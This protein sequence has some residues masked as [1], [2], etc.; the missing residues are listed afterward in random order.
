MQM[1]EWHVK[2][3]ERVCKV[4]AGSSNV[5]GTGGNG[6]LSGARRSDLDVFPGFKPSLE[7]CLLDWT[8]YP[9]EGITYADGGACRWYSP[10]MHTRLLEHNPR[11]DSIPDGLGGSEHLSSLCRRG[12]AVDESLF[13]F[14]AAVGHAITE[15]LVAAVPLTGDVASVNNGDPFAVGALLA[16][17]L[18]ADL[19]FSV[20][21][22]YFLPAA[23]V[24]MHQAVANQA[25]AWDSSS[26]SADSCS[27]H[28]TGIIFPYGSPGRT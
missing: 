23:A 4:R 18:A 13:A 9:I 24:L 7:A 6:G 11:G 5:A 3:L 14:T 16:T 8:D 19:D 21:P 15:G 20:G 26:A 10:Y 17:L 2:T 25:P 12:R 28:L 27:V 22:L 1:G